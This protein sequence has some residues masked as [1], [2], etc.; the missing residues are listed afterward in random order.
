MYP[1]NQP[2]SAA[3]NVASMKELF[4][5]A[6]PYDYKVASQRSN[7]LTVLG[8]RHHTDKHGHERTEDKSVRLKLSAYCPIRTVDIDRSYE[9]LEVWPTE[10]VLDWVGAHMININ[11]DHIT[12]QII[13]YADG[14]S[15]VWAKYG[16]I[17]GSR[18]LADFNKE[19]TQEWFQLAGYKPL[20]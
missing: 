7:A 20:P 14:T 17:I 19:Q 5:K 6:K 13:V 16:Q 2:E 12:F 18:L 4:R 9:A 10:L 11:Y 8:A 3:L 1:F 15:R